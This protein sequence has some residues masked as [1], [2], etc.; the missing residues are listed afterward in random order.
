VSAIGQLL[1]PSLVTRQCGF[2]FVLTGLV[3]SSAAEA[4]ACLENG[5][6]DVCKNLRI[7][8]PSGLRQLRLG[9]PTEESFRRQVA[10]CQSTA[11]INHE[12][13]AER[14]VVSMGW[15]RHCP[16][17]LVKVEAAGRKQCRPAE[18]LR[19]IE[20]LKHC[21]KLIPDIPLLLAEYSGLLLLLKARAGC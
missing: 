7:S 4:D 15:R 10:R 11:L 2:N 8:S 13:R 3:D 16:S 6:D 9:P 21:Q 12:T 14:A 19:Y 1:A 18:C 17:Y 5:S 20:T